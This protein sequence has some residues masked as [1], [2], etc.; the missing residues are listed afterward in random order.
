M[1]FTE[2]V[3]GAQYI[4]TGWKYDYASR[5]Y[6]LDLSSGTFTLG[7]YDI[8]QIRLTYGDEAVVIEYYNQL[9]ELVETDEYVYLVVAKQECT[10]TGHTYEVETIKEATCTGAGERRY[11]CSVC[12]DQKIED[13]PMTQHSSVYSILKDPTCS[14]VGLGLYTCSGC[15]M[16]YTEELPKL[17]HTGVLQEVVDSVY[18]D[19]GA[20]ITVGYSVYECS[21]CGSNYIVYDDTSTGT[22]SGFWGSLVDSFV[23]ALS[24]VI[25]SVLGFIMYVL[26]TLLKLVKDLIAFLYSFV[27]DTVLGGIRNMIAVFTDGSLFE[28]FQRDD[29]TVGLPAEISAV[30]S[31]FSGVIML[32]PWELR[33]VF[34]FGI[35]A[36]VLIAVFNLT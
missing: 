1:T 18:G 14:A 28:Y 21:L 8:L 31:F 16:Q 20:L 13:I 6:L 34:F 29:G 19:S 36:L 17:E 3:T 30:F 9:G 12:G 26:D 22:G 32:L 27:T 7:D 11:T 4:T 23:N 25:D 15:G 35:A 24:T 5:S 2:P 10:L 33:M